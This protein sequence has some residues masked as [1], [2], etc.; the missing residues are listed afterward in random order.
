MFAATTSPSDS[1]TW[2]SGPMPVAAPRAHVARVRAAVGQRP[3][4][5]DVADRPQALSGAQ[6]L[7]DL[8][9]LGVGLDADGLEADAL[10]AR[11]PPRGDEQPGDAP[12]RG[13]PAPGRRAAGRLAAAYRPRTPG[14][15][16]RRRAARRWRA[17][18]GS[19]R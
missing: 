15:T 8:D 14:R 1:P 12:R 2:V 11:A 5:G 4:A 13:G 19:A 7:V 16:R 10:D 6:V 17:S 9:A 18:R 3:D